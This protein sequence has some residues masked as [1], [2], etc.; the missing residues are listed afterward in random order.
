LKEREFIEMQRQVEVDI[1]EAHLVEGGITPAYKTPPGVAAPIVHPP[2]TSYREHDISEIMNRNDPE[3]MFASRTKPPNSNG[4]GT[5]LGASDREIK[6]E[7]NS[8]QLVREFSI[9]KLISP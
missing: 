9:F 2:P 1:V 6:G 7:L 5:N 4:V 3:N 8:A